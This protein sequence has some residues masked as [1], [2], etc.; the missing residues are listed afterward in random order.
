[1]ARAATAILPLR[2]FLGASF[3]Y[4][5][6]DKLVSPTFFDPT[7]AASIQA[8]MLAFA[9]FS[10][11]GG[12]IRLGQPF[13]AP[14][15]LAIAIA[16][17]AIGLGALTGLGFRLA[18]FGGLI[19]SALFFFTVSWTTR[20][21]YYG[22]DLPYAVGWVTLVI[23]GHGARFVPRSILEIDDRTDLSPG[24]RELLKAGWLGVVALAAASIALPFRA[25][26]SAGDVGDVASSPSVPAAT[27]GATIPSG[28]IAIAA[29]ADVDRTGFVAFTIPFDAP[30]PLPAGDPG[31][32][33]HLADGRFVAFD[34]VCTHAGCTVEWDRADAVLRCPC[35]GAAFDPA[36]DAAVLAGPTDQPL[37]SLPL[38]IDQT[39]GR[40]LLKA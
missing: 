13:A 32:I 19:L 15:G 27:P 34:A 26:R 3:L 22:P 10:P 14:I 11:I 40:I 30:A 33:V 28:A 12:L 35:H 9:T 25:V 23:A 36:H 7:S 24:R 16:E 8:Q 1:V 38:V 31:V 29:I 2:F 20:P 39:G 5:G 37:A 6:F 21:F 18:A 17:I 4:A